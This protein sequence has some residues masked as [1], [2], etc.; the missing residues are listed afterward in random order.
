MTKTVAKSVVRN[1]SESLRF[2]MIDRAKP[3]RTLAATPFVRKLWRDA[4]NAQPLR[5]LIA[6]SIIGVRG[7][8]VIIH[9]TVA[10]FHCVHGPVCAFDQSQGIFCMS[11]GTC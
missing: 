5:N 7:I 2:P 6:Q 8:D 11:E 9:V 3:A 1:I 10:A 4:L